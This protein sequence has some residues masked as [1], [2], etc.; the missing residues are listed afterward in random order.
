MVNKMI[1]LSLMLNILVLIPVCFGIISGNSTMLV[2]FGLQQPSL[3]ILLSVYLTILLASI[4]LLIKPN[5]SFIVM[6]LAMQVVYK[7]LTLFFVGSIK[8]PVV[9]SNLVI[10]V[11]HIVSLCLI[12]KLPGC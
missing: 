3:Q 11:I 1:T 10:S 7:M 8:N 5:I 12:K 4:Y 2:A 9:I 6:L